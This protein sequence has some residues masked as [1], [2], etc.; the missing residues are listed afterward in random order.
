MGL[1][2]DFLTLQI[3]MAVNWLE[4]GLVVTLNGVLL[5]GLLVLGGRFLRKSVPMWAGGAIGRFWQK[6]MEESDKEGTEGGGTTGRVKLGGFE[7]DVGTIKEL[8][9]I[10]PQL[11]QLAQ[12]FG[13]VKGGGGGGESPFTV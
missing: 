7:M 2:P 10:A 13:L 11:I 4:I 3:D 5:L 9:K 1:I 6:L 8:M 12:S